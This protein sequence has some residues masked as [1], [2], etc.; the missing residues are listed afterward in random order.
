MRE[1]NKR[2]LL[3]MM[4]TSGSKRDR[5][6]NGRYADER[7]LQ[8]NIDPENLP[9]HESIKSTSKF[10]NGKI[11]YGLLVRFLRGQTGNDWN[12]VYSEIIS[13]IPTK[14]L[15]YKDMVFNF[16]ADKV[17]MIDGRP[18]NK[19]TQQFIRTDEPYK[20]VHFTERKLQPEE[21]EF[22]VDPNTNKLVQIQRKSY[23]KY[24]SGT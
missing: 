22:Y 3:S 5:L 21:T 2:W 19:K 11:N 20:T 7:H 16:V 6:Q 24:H 9:S 14:L 13:R 17:E 1:D 18:W 4:K 10:Y 23:K 12:E 8:K 15:D